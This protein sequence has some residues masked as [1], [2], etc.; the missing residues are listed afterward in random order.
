MAARA[1]T[2]SLS[3]TNDLGVA[4]MRKTFSVVGASPHQVN[5]SSRN[6]ASTLNERG[7]C[8]QWHDISIMCAKSARA[9]SLAPRKRARCDPRAQSPRMRDNGYF[10]AVPRGGRA[11][12][13]AVSA[14]V[15]NRQSAARTRGARQP[16]DRSAS[17][18]RAGSRAG[19][20]GA[21]LAART[22]SAAC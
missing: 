19:P 3:A 18:A 12:R 8:A 22:A 15:V 20:C 7:R 11:A 14:P 16:S 6:G 17:E 2:S 5:V 10:R 9:S 4:C 1:N 13:G 21:P